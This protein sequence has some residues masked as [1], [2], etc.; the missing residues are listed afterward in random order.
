M[1]I[2]FSYGRINASILCYYTILLQAFLK[3]SVG[4]LFLVQFGYGIACIL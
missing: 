2:N 1:K 3:L 4:Y